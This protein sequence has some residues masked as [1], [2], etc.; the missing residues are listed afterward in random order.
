MQWD[1]PN[2]FNAEEFAPTYVLVFVFVV[3]FEVWNAIKSTIIFFLDLGMPIRAEL[4]T[5]G[6]IC[7][8]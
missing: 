7:P 5:H 3:D 4:F 2:D 1:S 8:S 6:L